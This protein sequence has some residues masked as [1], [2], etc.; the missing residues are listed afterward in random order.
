MFVFLLRGRKHE[1]TNL[2]IK[3]I[4]MLPTIKKQNLNWFPNVLNEFFNEDWFPMRNGQTIPAINVKEKEKSFEIEMAVPGISKE[5]TRVYV[6]KK[7][8]LVITV[9]KKMEK[10]EEDKSSKFLRQEFK[11][12]Q[13]EQTLLLPENI[14]R[15][16][17]T[18]K[19]CHGVLHIKLPKLEDVDT[20]QQVQV[21][22]IQ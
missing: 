4:I 19:V 7:D 5:D 12:A 2:T 22:D 17:I 20:R 14:D 8:Q 1:A 10:K 6:N 16:A 9:E 15:E 3:F 13:F 21:I 11:M 18:A